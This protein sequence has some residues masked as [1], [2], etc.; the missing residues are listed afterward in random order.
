[1]DIK[2]EDSKTVY[3][4]FSQ[5]SKDISYSYRCEDD[6]NCKGWYNKY[7]DTM[8]YIARIY[9]KFN[10]TRSLKERRDTP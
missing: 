8:T 9:T 1:M 7:L 5:L 10:L 6:D 4:L 3:E 2:K